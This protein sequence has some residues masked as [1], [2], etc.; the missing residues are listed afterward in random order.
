MVLRE[1]NRVEESTEDLTKRQQDTHDQ[2]DQ[3]VTVTISIGVA[4]R[5]YRDDKTDDVLKRADAELYKAK[6]AG[7]NRLKHEQ[8]Q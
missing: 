8:V 7:R 1:H 2:A 4:S 5:Q 6:N 3:T